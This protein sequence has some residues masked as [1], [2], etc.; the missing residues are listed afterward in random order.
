MDIK[1]VLNELLPD[2]YWILFIGF[3]FIG[4]HW[5]FIE[6]IE[7]IV[8]PSK[9]R[10]SVIS[11]WPSKG[12]WSVGKQNQHKLEYLI[13]ALY[14]TF[15]N[16]PGARS[17][18]DFPK[19]VHNINRHS[20]KYHWPKVVDDVGFNPKPNPNLNPNVNPSKW[21]WDGRRG[22]IDRPETFQSSFMTS[23]A[24]WHESKGG[25]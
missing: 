3:I 18:R 1:C 15:N 9:G 11:A 20:A 14:W 17:A 10:R 24:I 23:I 25:A 6:S 22:A 21:D 5:I 13:F 4:F 12:R 19:F 2:F 7:F 8:W 16:R